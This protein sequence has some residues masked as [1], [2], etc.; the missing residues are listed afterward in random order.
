MAGARAPP[1]WQ[2]EEEHR[3]LTLKACN[4][5]DVQFAA[6]DYSNLSDGT[7]ILWEV[8]PYFAV[9]SPIMLPRRRRA[10]ER[11][12]SYHETI[13]KFLGALLTAPNGTRTARIA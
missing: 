9:F 5:V 12:V 10:P 11:L 7:P 3:T 6:I 4:A 2:Q 8:N 1:Y 13:G